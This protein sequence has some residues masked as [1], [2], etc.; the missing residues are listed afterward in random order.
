MP[1]TFGAL[2]LTFPAI[3]YGDKA[4]P[5]DLKVLLYR[6]GAKAHPGKVG[7]MIAEGQLGS[8]V[9]ERAE[10]VRRIHEAV[11]G[12]LV[13]G[14]SIATARNSVRYLRDLFIWAE[15][16]HHQLDFDS[17]QKTYIHWTDALLN[18]C[19]V[20]GDLKKRSAYTKGSQAG[21][22]LDAVL[23]RSNPVIQLTRL[24]M[25]SQR[26][27]ARGVQADKQS[28]NDTFI[29]GKLLQDICD[30]LQID[31]VLKGP[32][33]V[34]IPLHTGGE[35]VQ[36][37]GYS[38]QGGVAPKLAG[39][40][41]QRSIKRF[42]AFEADGTL[43]TR[44][45]LANLRC[46]A[47]LLMF[48]GQT[49]MNMA[50]AHKL[51]LRHFYYASHLDGYQVKDRKQRRGGEV[52]FEIF[53]GYKPHFERYLEWRREIFP[54]S[55]LLFPFVRIGGRADH[56][57]PQFRLRSIFKGLG[58]CFV[59]PQTL[60]N[61]RINWLLR[62]S[63]DPELTACMAQ[64]TKETLLSVYERPSQQRAMSEV[65][66]FWS[67]YDPTIVRTTSVAPGQCNGQ[68]APVPSIP[69]AAPTPDCI[70]PSGCLWCEHHRDV[71]SEDH[72]W[73]L[74]S[75]RHLKVIELSKWHSPAVH[76]EALPVRHVVDR[77]TEKL[78]WFHGSN[79]QRR[80]WMDEALARVEEGR[81]HPDWHRL[82][83]G[84][85]GAP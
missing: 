75:F 7:R 60:R 70:R 36:W 32:L 3:T 61:T 2:D 40:H 68:L 58:I 17:I 22:V 21:Q 25:P 31:V 6:G 67:R 79:A 8:P 66:R 24:D 65:M 34:R 84:M 78:R 77:I 72:V 15:E 76:Q 83:V 69:I 4:T 80:S 33:P 27:T 85:E 9:R 29:F 11:N 52:L 48:I 64:H 43:R 12:K 46:E 19:Q 39:L 51:Q 18:R 44:Y 53:K 14:G 23:D 13:G 50:Q 16:A 5:L 57:A 30:G 56:T 10:L 45:P 62:R 35:L 73:A 1:D 63:S 20:V 49:G 28:L 74:A 59:P 26:K 82:I 42:T 37:S 55:D 47:E 54:T 81:Y 71:D 38:C 41:S